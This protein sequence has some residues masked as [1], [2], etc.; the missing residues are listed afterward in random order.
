MDEQAWRSLRDDIDTALATLREYQQAGEYE[1]LP[2]ISAAGQAGLDQW[3]RERDARRMEPEE[4][5]E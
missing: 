2:E 5:G 3:Y 1:D 4:A